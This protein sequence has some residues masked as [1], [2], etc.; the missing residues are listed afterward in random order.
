MKVCTGEGGE[1]GFDGSGVDAGPGY[2]TPPDPDGPGVGTDGLGA[3]VGVMPGLVVRNSG[4]NVSEP[5]VPRRNVMLIVSVP[6]G[7]KLT[8][9]K[10]VEPCDIPDG[11]LRM[12]DTNGGIGN[13]MTPCTAVDNRFSAV[14]T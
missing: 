8:F 2:T 1:I 14:I 13:A 11:S 12:Y 3:D 6:F 5:A 4:C 9:H 10:T 7:S